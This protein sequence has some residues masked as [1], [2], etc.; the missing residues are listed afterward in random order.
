MREADFEG[1]AVRAAIGEWSSG[2]ADR[3]ADR[4]STHL[5]ALRAHFCNDDAVAGIYSDSR[6]WRMAR[7]T[8]RSFK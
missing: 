1:H 2:R 4:M 3:S 6:R 7:H 8:P 5:R